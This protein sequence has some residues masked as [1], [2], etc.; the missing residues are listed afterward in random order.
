MGKYPLLKYQGL[1]SMPEQIISLSAQAL[2]EKREG[3]LRLVN[4]NEFWEGMI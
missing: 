2:A 4:F 1:C 3:T